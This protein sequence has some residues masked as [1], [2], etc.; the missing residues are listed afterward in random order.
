MTLRTYL[1]ALTLL[2][3]PAC[4]TDHNVGNSPPGLGATRWTIS[5]G[6]TADEVGLDIATDSAGHVIASGFYQGP[7]DFGSGE[8]AIGANRSAWLTKRA[9]ADGAELWTRVFGEAGKLF[10]ITQVI[11]DNDDSVIVTGMYSGAQDFGGTELIG[12]PGDMFVAKFSANGNLLWAR[13]LGTSSRSGA[14][15]VVV[16]SDDRIYVS[17]FFSGTVYLPDSVVVA[18]TKELFVAAFESDGTPRWF[19]KYANENSE[20]RLALTDNGDLIAVTTISTPIALGGITISPVAMYSQA[21][22]R[23]SPDGDVIWARVRG[24]VGVPTLAGAVEVLADGRLLVASMTQLSTGMAGGVNGLS[25]LDSQGNGLWSSTSPSSEVQISGFAELPSG[26]I[27]A[28]GQIAVATTALDEAGVGVVPPSATTFL[29]ALD[30]EGLPLDGHVF[31]DRFASQ[32]ATTGI[33]SV[34]PLASGGVAFTGQIG[35]G[36]DFGTGPLPYHAKSDIVIGV[37]DAGE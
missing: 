4:T 16:G 18:S 17:G 13:G 36:A 34:A 21:L 26:A 22:A 5:L 27:V 15:S 24:D 11:V 1:A 32:T 23:I 37:I 30:G 3:V 35:Y 6:G 10:D 25:V 9:A 7:V 33:R 28:S 29:R 8:V 20:L 19:N 31:G 2:A 14:T 12:G